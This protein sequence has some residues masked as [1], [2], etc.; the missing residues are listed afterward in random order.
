MF[1][2]KVLTK[3]I[4]YKKR[5]NS[6][7]NSGQQSSPNY[8]ST[9]RPKFLCMTRTLEEPRGNASVLD[10]SSWD[11]DDGVDTLLNTRETVEGSQGE[12]GGD[13]RDGEGRP[14][15][16]A[17]PT[18]VRLTRPPEVCGI[19]TGPCGGIRI[20]VGCAALPSTGDF[21]VR[22]RLPRERN[23]HFA[24]ISVSLDPCTLS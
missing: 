18:M 1:Q 2:R 24:G 19:S 16:A 17:N 12:I 9:L 13:D 4:R 5:R 8:L 6:A 11:V 10:A 21:V 14:K 15:S 3:K 22:Q 7:H 23:A 20:E